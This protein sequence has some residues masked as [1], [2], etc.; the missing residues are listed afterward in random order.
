M[1]PEE[2]I[3]RWFLIYSYFK[4]ER[5]DLKMLW[6]VLFLS[7]TAKVFVWFFV[8]LYATFVHFIVI[9]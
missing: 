5:K 2:Y 6:F 7:W 9:P 8:N 3:I 4:N 1:Q